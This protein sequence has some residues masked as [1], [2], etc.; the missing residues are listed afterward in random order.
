MN[1]LWIVTFETFLRQVK[2]WGFVVLILGPFL[3]FGISIGAGYMSASSASSSDKIAV[4]GQSELK[5]AFV[6][7]NK[8]DVDTEVQ[9]EKSAEKKI[10]HNN[11]AGYLS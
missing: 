10:K 3:I 4:F 6:K 7:Q 11:L 5:Q 9:S 1:K 2:S 8:D